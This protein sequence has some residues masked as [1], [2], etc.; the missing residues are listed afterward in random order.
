MKRQ[1]RMI[2]SAMEVDAVNKAI[3][4]NTPAVRYS[5]SHAQRQEAARLWQW[6][7]ACTDEDYEGQCAQEQAIWEDEDWGQVDEV[8]Q[9]RRTCIGIHRKLLIMREMGTRQSIAQGEGHG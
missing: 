5:G 3:R 1:E 4:E 2:P 7:R 9:V 8:K 6:I